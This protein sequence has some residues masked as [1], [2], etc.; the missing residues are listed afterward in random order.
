M[1]VIFQLILITTIWCLGVKIVTA[2][3]MAL[4]KLGRWAEKKVNEAN[5]IYE[6]LLTCH[7]CLPS[8]HSLFG[9]AFAVGIGVIAEFEWK[10]VFMWPLVVMGSS[11][12]CGCMWEIIQILIKRNG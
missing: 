12:L 5:K 10:L 1:I 9:Y 11:V 2:E 3:G 6:P 7:F 4:E 8:I